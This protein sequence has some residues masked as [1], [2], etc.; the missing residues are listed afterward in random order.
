MNTADPADFRGHICG[1]VYRVSISYMDDIVFNVS[2][3]NMS[4]TMRYLHKFL[5]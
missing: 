5:Y 2:I 4:H 3:V 1:D